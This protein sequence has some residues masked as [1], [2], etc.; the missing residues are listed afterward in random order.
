M[1]NPSLPVT[2]S[3]VRHPPVGQCI[4]C[5]D[6]A[7][8][9]TDEHIIAEGLGG[10]EVLPAASCLNC[11]RITGAF[12]QKVLRHAIWPL[13]HQMGMGGKKRKRGDTV[14]TLGRRDG[15]DIYAD[16]PPSKVG[17]KA[18]LPIFWNPPG[19]L[20]GILPSED[21]G[22]DWDIFCD[23]DY[24]GRK[25][26]LGCVANVSAQN[27][28]LMFAK[29][30]H[31]HAVATLGIGTFEPFLPAVILG[32]NPCWSFFVGRAPVVD[33]EPE[34]V[35]HRYQL[36]VMQDSPR[37][38]IILSRIRLFCQ[39]SGPVYDVAVGRLYTAKPS[40]GGLA[41]VVNKASRFARQLVMD[42][43]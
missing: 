30:G 7:G 36:S 15:Q 16:L 14:R 18:V 39:L 20:A 19:L 23:A 43:W 29:I 25:G 33:D 10:R 22:V 8:R 5:G 13:R 28:A 12:E 21:V 32:K 37:Q 1:E 17:I 4:Y 27:F 34:P 42:R 31:A 6:K 35:G 26:D 11:A 9:L 41:R 40:L 38:D 3:G 24:I 2:G